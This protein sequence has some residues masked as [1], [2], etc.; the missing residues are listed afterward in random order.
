VLRYQVIKQELCHLFYL[1][2]WTI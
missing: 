1:S 2:L